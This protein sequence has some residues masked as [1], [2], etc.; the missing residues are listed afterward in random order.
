MASGPATVGSVKIVVDDS[1]RNESSALNSPLVSPAGGSTSSKS[2]SNYGSIALAPVTPL[3]KKEVVDSP[4]ADIVAIEPFRFSRCGAVLFW[5]LALCTGGL[6]LLVSYWLPR[7]STPLRYTRCSPDEADFMLVTVQSLINSILTH[8]CF[9][10]AH[11][12]H[13]L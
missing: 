4:A 8:I 9:E 1:K 12:C 6:S 10:H 3:R 5:L 13:S 7:H 2:G 11:M